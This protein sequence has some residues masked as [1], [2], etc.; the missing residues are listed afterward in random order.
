[1]PRF[2]KC[3]VYDKDWRRSYKCHSYHLCC[4]AK[5]FG[6]NKRRALMLE[7]VA[8]LTTMGISSATVPVLLNLIR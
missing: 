4:W 8:I 3:I 5:A 1:M 2:N 7:E 6:I